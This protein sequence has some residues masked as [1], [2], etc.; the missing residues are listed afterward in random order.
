MN[1][2]DA[3]YQMGYAVFSYANRENSQ[4]L[5]DAINFIVEHSKDARWDCIQR[6]LE[7]MENAPKKQQ[8]PKTEA[9]FNLIHKM[10]IK[11]FKK[12]MIYYSL[13]HDGF[14]I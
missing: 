7:I 3:C 14:R 10:M 6:S 13:C 2:D 11:E 12:D 1:Y 5:I 9:F 4:R 8:N